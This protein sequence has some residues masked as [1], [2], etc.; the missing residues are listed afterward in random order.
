M[1]VLQQADLSAHEWLDLLER[2]L[3]VMD[4]VVDQ[5]DDAQLIFESLNS[6]G[7]NLTESDKI[8]NFY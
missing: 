1:N 6:T 4:I 7:M 2:R 3:Q 5:D 8:R